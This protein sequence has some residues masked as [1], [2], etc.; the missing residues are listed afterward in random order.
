MANPPDPVRKWKI[1]TIILLIAVLLLGWWQCA[2][3]RYLRN[4]VRPLLPSA[5]VQPP[6]GGTVPKPPP[7]I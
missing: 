6:D 1:L 4:E 3:W 2:T 7:R 5:A